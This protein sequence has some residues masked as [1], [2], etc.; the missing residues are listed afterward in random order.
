VTEARLLSNN[1]KEDNSNVEDLNNILQS[2]DAMG[3]EEAAQHLYGM[4]YGDWK[5]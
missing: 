2:L 5:K 3:K 1:L 4:N